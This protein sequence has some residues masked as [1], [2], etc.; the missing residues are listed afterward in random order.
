MRLT[1]VI[2]SLSSGGAE[3]VMSIMAN[4]WAEKAWPVSLLT[5]DDGREAPFYKLH[6]KVIRIALGISAPS[7]NRL[8]GILNN[9]ERICTLRGAIRRSEPDV[10]I[11]FME[12][13]NVLTL[14]ATV[15]LNLPVVVSERIDP[16]FYPIGKIWSCLRTWAYRRTG[17]LVVQTESAKAFF[18]EP[19]QR[20][21]RVIPNPVIRPPESAAGSNRGIRKQI[22]GIGRLTPQKG[23]DLLLNAFAQ[24]A[25]R[26]PDWSVVVWGDGEA[27][28]AL[29][30]QR[31]QLGLRDQ[32]RFPGRTKRPFQQL[33]EAD[34]FI[35]SSRFEGFPNALCEA[36]A[37]GLPVIS[38]DCQSG[39][40]EIIR[41]NVD[42]LLVPNGDVVALASAMERLMSNEDELKRL[43]SR[44]VEVIERFGLEKIM[45][46]WGHV[47]NNAVGG[48]GR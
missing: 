40:R 17:C 34:L 35:L 8:Q 29:E 26:H 43:S 36:M 44:A 13:V 21:T 1:L 32:V 27:R 19:I 28:E 31:D 12:K 16:H 10:V 6:P 42:G 39:P 7:A 3:R 20:R 2:S 48:Q 41:D 4:Y 24:I 47:L 22:I 33:R 9:L 45:A 11:A 38:F 15:G 5:L 14:L 30:Q 46:T 18:S 25:S 37:C 23:F